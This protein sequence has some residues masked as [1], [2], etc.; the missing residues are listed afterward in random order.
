MR[1]MH[2]AD[3]HLGNL[4]YGLKDRYN[5][6][7][8][9][10]RYLID[11]ALE[12]PVEG[13]LLAGDLFDKQSVD[14]LA[15]RVAVQ[16]FARLRDAG[17]PVLAVEGNHV[18]AA[19]RHQDS[20]IDFLNAFGY[21]RLLSYDPRKGLRP[22]GEEGGAYVD[23]PGGVRV[24]G[25]GYYGAATGRVLGQFAA[26][27]DDHDKGDVRYTIF[28]A[29]TGLEGQLAHLRGSTYEEFAPL[30]EHIDYIALGHFHKPFEVD[31]WI[32]NP[33][34]PETCSMDE[35]AW[36]QRGYYLV[37]VLPDTGTRHRAELRAVPRRPFHRFTL[38]VD[39]YTDPASVYDG[40]RDL[41]ARKDSEVAPASRPIIQL[42]LTGVL[43]FSR[44]DLDL[45]YIQDLLEE[46][47]NPL[48]RPQVVNRSTPAEFEMGL[49]LEI[50]RAELEYQVV[51]QLLERD[52]R[53]RA[54]AAEWTGGVLELKRL[55]LGGGPPE[56][57]VEHLRRLRDTLQT[58]AEED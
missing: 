33:G 23:L 6:F 52:S 43:P 17:I 18:R 14:P 9:A 20:W 10:F 58:P 34:S 12:E 28:L 56:A 32:Y 2:I 31:D 21:L 25:M 30:R 37:E 54:D 11:V 19:Y 50:G 46:A 40:V 35:V 36:P 4:Q 13:L 1:F 26:A 42:S 47:W 51:R 53:F 44:Y 27:L 41:I 38:P 45:V 39:G 5:D 24:Y 7:T 22:H 29:H 16:E 8:R 3:I 57:V 55:A 49:D 48:G 15:M